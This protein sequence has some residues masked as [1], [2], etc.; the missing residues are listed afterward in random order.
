M[1]ALKNRSLRNWLGKQGLRLHNLSATGFNAKMEEQYHS[2]LLFFHAS[3]SEALQY[4]MK[5]IVEEL[6][7][8]CA[9]SK[10]CPGMTLVLGVIQT[11]CVEK[12]IPSHFK[13]AILI[14]EL[15][16]NFIHHINDKLEGIPPDRLHLVKEE[17]LFNYEHSWPS[18]EGHIPAIF[19]KARDVL[20]ETDVEAVENDIRQKR[21]QQLES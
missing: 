3:R 9:S 20:W 16:S 8:F 17:E 21:M 18:I 5:H 19:K 15:K 11:R 4:V 6:I 13:G 14:K 10:G 2:P 7:S 12:L 1:Q